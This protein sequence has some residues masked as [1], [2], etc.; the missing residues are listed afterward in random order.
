MIK[1]SSDGA[2]ALSFRCKSDFS[3]QDAR[4]LARKCAE[5]LAEEATAS[6]PAMP[7]QEASCASSFRG[8]NKPEW[9][10]YTAILAPVRPNRFLVR[11][12]SYFH[13][14]WVNIG[15]EKK[16]GV[17][18]NVL[19]QVRLPRGS[20]QGMYRPRRIMPSA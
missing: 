3:H 14:V 11:K 15:K 13:F 18:F 20:K 16:T 8:K 5:L 12:F 2:S 17:L 1:K 6:T 19:L 9:V 7:P 4:S 10:K